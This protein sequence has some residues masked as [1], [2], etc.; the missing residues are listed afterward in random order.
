MTNPA[1]IHRAR[2]DV[3]HVLE[4]L[5]PVLVVNE[6]YLTTDGD[7]AKL[8]GQEKIA[9]R[10]TRELLVEVAVLRTRRVV[11]EGQSRPVTAKTEWTLSR[12]LG[13]A[14]G[15]LTVKWQRDDAHTHELMSQPNPAKGRKRRAPAATESMHLNGNGAYTNA[16]VSAANH[17]ESELVHVSGPDAPAPLASLAPERKDDPG[18]LVEAARQYANLHTQVERKLKE[19]EGMGIHV[20]WEKVA[21]AVQLPSDP[22]LQ[23]VAD[24]LPYIERLER[25]N[26]RLTAQAEALREKANLSDGLMRE[27]ARLKDQV[28]RLVA[29]R[30]ALRDNPA[31]ARQPATAGK[32]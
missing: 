7:L 10:R 19:L 1:A 30:V 32:A 8:I 21:K 9:V 5:Q 14:K 6:P 11:P 4:G 23:A 22:R 13:E 17:P 28:A 12:P 26:E 31:P 18:A 16:T 25:V 15:R 20:E 27:N 29:E 2:Q 3:L 24:A